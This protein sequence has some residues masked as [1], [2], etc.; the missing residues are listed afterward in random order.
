MTSWSNGQE[1]QSASGIV[2]KKGNSGFL[3]LQK[4]SKPERKTKSE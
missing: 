2:L 1:L 4:E 3:P